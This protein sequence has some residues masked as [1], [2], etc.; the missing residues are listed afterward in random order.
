MK[1]IRGAHALV[2]GASRG[3][4]PRIA[5]ALAVEGANVTLT[6]RSADALREAAEA[7][8]ARPAWR[9]RARAVAEAPQALADAQQA[10]GEEGLVLVTGSIYLA[11]ALRAHT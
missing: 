11:G 7:L 2:T 1:T 8:A 6:A 5:R 4:G 9:G 10:A 3:L